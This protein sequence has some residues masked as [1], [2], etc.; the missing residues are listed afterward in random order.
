MD[1][2]AAL[3]GAASARHAGRGDPRLRATALAAACR[4]VLAADGA[5]ISVT[6]DGQWRLPIGASDAAAAAAE[7]WQFTVGQGPGF[8]AWAEGGVVV[9]GE[10]SLRRAWPV[11]HDQLHRR[12]PFR[13][14]VSLPLR[15]GPGPVG[16]V[17]LHFHRAEPVAPATASFDPVRAQLVAS[18]IDTDLFGPGAPGPAPAG[19][20]P[21]APAWLDAPTARHR[22]RVWMVISMS[23]QVLG[24][25]DADALALLRARAYSRDRTLEELADDVVEGRTPVR[26]L[27]HSAED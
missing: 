4:D 19:R 5:T 3:F 8:R 7:R 21:G 22:Q 9:A 16:V 15:P 11:L 2:V 18:L 6:S 14:T 12:T 25:T 24:L 26:A 13:S 27:H 10:A 20:G 1:D 23:R 17:D